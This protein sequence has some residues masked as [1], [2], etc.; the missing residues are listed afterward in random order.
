MAK[1]EKIENVMADDKIEKVVMSI[2]DGKE[3]IEGEVYL[4]F[5]DT[6][7]NKRYVVYTTE[8][9][10]N[11]NDRIPFVLSTLVF[12]DNGYVLEETTK[13]D[14]QNIEL[15][16]LN[17]I[18]LNGDKE[19]SEVLN[20]INEK[21]PSIAMLSLQALKTNVENMTISETKPPKKANMPIAIA[22]VI[23]KFYLHQLNK[24]LKKVYNATEMS[25]IEKAATVEKLD[26]LEGKLDSVK[27]MYEE[28]A[29]R[30]G[31]PTASIEKSLDQ[32]ETAKKD[33]EAAKNRINNLPEEVVEEEIEVSQ[34]E[35][36][37]IEQPETSEEQP[38]VEPSITE[39]PVEQ[40]QQVEDV[41]SEEVQ[42]EV[43]PEEI[44]QLVEE[45]TSVE[46]A[47]PTKKKQNKKFKEME[48]KDAIS[49]KD[50]V[51]QNGT[52]II[53]D[54][55]TEVNMIIGVAVDEFAES[56]EKIVNKI[57]NGICDVYDYELKKK[58][59]I[60]QQL[61]EQLT[62]QEET[63][64]QEK[65]D[66]LEQITKLGE[67]A[68]E[69]NQ[70]ANHS[71][72]TIEGLNSQLVTSQQNEETLKKENEDLKS[73]VTSQKQLLDQQNAMMDSL[74][75]ESKNRDEQ[76]QAE[77]K[78]LKEENNKLKIYEEGYNK[79]AGMFASKPVDP[80]QQLIEE[81]IDEAL[82]QQPKK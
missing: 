48:P 71:K 49:V 52:P 39:N 72:E 82:S 76:Q 25:D 13:E 58:D 63:N 37:Q 26:E 79:I 56:F 28:N 38:V 1:I 47:V 22:N 16:V 65:M 20:M 8:Q 15:P 35:E 46:K 30:R 77:I 51:E 61:Q 4:G 14:H 54:I 62:K 34:P 60:I 75:E 12:E 21:F 7:T 5:V 6:N 43:V 44:K 80:K 19:P 18:G 81:A 36:Q 66:M 70:Q 17:I 29:E 23:K 64:K 67:K 50:L 78:A 31:G 3:V 27:E 74:R 59:A 45:A 10:K 69:V 9:A 11:E 53:S 73:E 40:E 42:P 32:I 33:I 55:D 57:S 2:N 68:Q 41:Q 24:E